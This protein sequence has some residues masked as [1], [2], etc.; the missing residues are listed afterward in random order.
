[1]WNRLAGIAVATWLCLGVG[2]LCAAEAAGDPP[3]Q[4]RPERDLQ[5]LAEALGDRLE[6]LGEKPEDGGHD[7]ALHDAW[8]SALKS[9]AS[10]IHHPVRDLTKD[11]VWYYAGNP[12]RVLR[13]KDKEWSR[14]IRT[15]AR[16]YAAL[17]TAHKI[18]GKEKVSPKRAYFLWDKRNPEPDLTG[19][20]PAGRD[21]VGVRNTINRYRHQGIPVPS[22]LTIELARLVHLE[23]VQIAE[24]EARHRRWKA[25]RRRAREEIDRAVAATKE[26]LRARRQHLEALQGAMRSMIAQMQQA[27]E[28]RLTQITE[29]YF[30]DT[31]FANDV[32]DLMRKMQLGR[33]AA[34]RY[35]NIGRSSRYGSL[36]R[37]GWTVHRAKLLSR[38]GRAERDAKAAAEAANAAGAD[39]ESGAEPSDTPPKADDEAPATPDQ[40][41][42]EPVDTPGK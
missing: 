4:P 31:E 25:D 10:H 41:G 3:A 23:A 7:G 30:G 1:M 12:P 14:A 24:R 8:K 2:I 37:S 19:L 39:T 11:K 18:Y 22:S 15:L 38:L 28:L 33:E 17:G 5:D 34:L 6:A 42:K 27:E 26:A 13:L 35:D 36:I 20:T 29:P 9:R 32:A 21:L 16:S 40:P